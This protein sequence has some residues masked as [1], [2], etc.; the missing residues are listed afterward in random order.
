MS[1]RPAPEAFAS[2]AEVY[3]FYIP[4]HVRAFY[5]PGDLERFLRARFDFF[6]QA[7]DGIRLDVHNP[8]PEFFW[9]INSSV[10][11][12]VMPDAPFIVDTILDYCASQDIKVN[13]VIHPVLRAV[14]QNGRLLRVDFSLEGAIEPEGRDESYVYLEIARK[15]P[16]EL[17]HISAEIHA[18]LKDL[19][20]IVHDFP[21]ML[22]SMETLRFAESDER[23]E[24]RWLAEHFVMLGT[25]GFDDPR[26]GPQP[27]FHGL[28]RKQ[29]M[30]TAVQSEAD[31]LQLH[32][33]VV[34][35]VETSISSDVNRRKR[36]QLVALR[37]RTESLLLIGH[38]TH[39]ARRSFRDD[40]PSIK[41]KL[42]DVAAAMRAAPE[43]HVRKELF[44]CAEILPLSVLASRSVD[45]LGRLLG[46][47]VSSVY[48]DEADF[49]YFLDPDYGLLWIVGLV[50]QRDS[51]HVPTR[52]FWE[53]ASTEQLEVQH[54]VRSEMGRNVAVL[55]ALRSPAKSPEALQE[56]I[57]G[58]AGLF[59]SSW[60]ARFRRAISNRFV[61]DEAIHDHLR[62]YFYGI[63]ADYENHLSPEETL[64][65]LHL[66]DRMHPGEYSVHYQPGA[67]GTDTVKVYTDRPSNL[68]DFVPVLTNFGFV[69]NTE[70]TFPFRR[71]GLPTAFIYSFSVPHAEIDADGR[72]R[73][74]AAVAA[75]LNGQGTSEAMNGL[76][77]SA[78]FD[79]RSLQIAK[80]LA[81]YIF[82][83]DRSYSRLY[84]QQT[85]LRYPKF[86][87]AL[88]AFLLARHDPAGTDHVVASAESALMETFAELESVLDEAVCRTFVA[89]A[90]AVVRT[91]LSL[92]REEISFK[93][94]SGEIDGMPRPVP[95]FE[96]YVYSH[97]LEGIHLRGGMTA[98]GGIRWSDRPDD[99]RTEVLGLMK[100][101][102]VKNTVIVP[103]GS[104]GGFVL[105]N[106]TFPDRES[107]RQAG[108]ESYRRYIQCLLDLTD[109]LSPTGRIVPARGVR[110]LDGDDAY[111]VVAADKGTATFSD[112]ANQVS[113][114]NHFWLGDAF[115][116]GGGNGYDHKVQGITARGAWEA[117]RRHFHE[118]GIN[119]E[120]DPVRVVGIGDMSGD[121]FGN[122]LLLSRSLR[123]LAAFNHLYIFL[124]PDPDPEA[125]YVERER[126][127]RGV[128]NWNDYNPK[129]ISKGGG[130][131]DRAARR[132]ALSK[133]VRAAL[134]IDRPACSGEELVRA[135]LCAPV[136]L[137]WNGGIGT[138]VKAQAESH[139]Q[140]GDATNDRVRI[141]AG[142]IR[143]RVVAEGGNLGL[144]Q[145]ARIEAAA[146]NVR[147]NTDAIDNSAGVDMSDH[148]V[149]LKVLLNGLVRQ[150][151][152][153]GAADRNRLIRKYE[154]EMV[155]LVLAHN[156]FNNLGLSV[157]ERRVPSQ[158]TYFRALIRFLNREGILSREQ[159][160]I[161]FEADLERIEQTT[162][163]LARP[164]LASLMG[165]S[166]L[167]LAQKFEASTGFGDEWYD[168]FLLRY[169]PAAAVRAYRDPILRH[170]L[171]RQIII[172]EVVNET[173]NHAG[174]AFY[175]RMFMRTGRPVEQ[176][177]DGY[178][179]L[180]DFLAISQLRSA[181]PT[182]LPA[183]LHYEYIMLL[184]EQLFLVLRRILEEGRSAPEGNPA[185]FVR[186]LE[187]CM[188]HSTFRVRRELRGT[189]R[190]LSAED[191]ERVT[192]MFRR[193]DVLPDAFV[194]HRLNQGRRHPW[195]VTEYF[196][197]LDEY[198]IRELRREIRNLNPSSTWEILF[199]SKL[200]EAVEQ[201]T[202]AL[203]VAERAGGPAQK[204]RLLALLHEM[205]GRAGAA[206]RSAAAMYEMLQ[207]ARERLIPAQTTVPGRHK[208]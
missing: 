71:E 44:K 175:Q 144:T 162:R 102:M 120:R 182:W 6:S 76:A 206:S 19:E 189:L 185:A 190:S 170:P 67:G 178:M 121:V 9:L 132:I 165:F 199:L 113:E 61:G 195:S 115:A 150:K 168:R 22:S 18:N 30:R 156:Y 167:Y 174:I 108:V 130:V 46:R 139:Y 35:Y 119:P 66:I 114:A 95:L 180:V 69:I 145:A 53:F 197:V 60:S 85:L 74:G 91:N 93:I 171:K 12:T 141:D 32:G 194:L 17:R 140:A 82:Q 33:P 128:L 88:L 125:S 54:D 136:D 4:E 51:G 40:V 94:R 161:P 155:R 181:D 138:Y 191:G 56:E 201:I 104:K 133:E 50:P 110:R 131:F 13:M 83:I 92:G 98:R 146:H 2:F 177:A 183:E 42:T 31:H 28:L 86:A 48:S 101:Q 96:I 202:V 7:T 176:I 129:L 45:L 118:L 58:A 10:I 15:T 80:A 112:I 68:S 57:E 186:L 179:R 160:A 26:R 126:L 72:R 154:P 192:G 123:L 3:T 151:K 163:R 184:E 37:G 55:L 25:A 34:Q 11:E 116:S 43:S 70:R 24:V 103:V 148:E 143:A 90:R 29:P 200:E 20:T 5:A 1:S 198:R 84:L 135:I 62:R 75:V 87:A 77:V 64:H 158:F 196:A 117:V 172:T 14:R 164:V 173:V 16:R 142:Q 134:G 152:L 124:D 97:R 107:F 39:R 36:L 166:K 122:G 106:R 65:D 41:R 89:V 137:L 109:N 52:R 159:D 208:G 8:G 111:L 157:D 169:F 153:S 149:N 147:L 23:D 38:F 78:G 79:A 204:E 105:K 27:P 59:F 205:T 187:E 193:M 203:A 99:F 100:A 49:S 63:N 73:V 188:P 47:L 21:H 127:F 207:F 81:G